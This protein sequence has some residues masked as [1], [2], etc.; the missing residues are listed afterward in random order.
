MTLLV[1]LCF[2]KIFSFFYLFS[3]FWMVLLGFLGP[4][5]MVDM[6][7]SFGAGTS[8]LQTLF[9]RG[10]FGVA[11]APACACSMVTLALIAGSEF[12]RW[13][14]CI[15]VTVSMF[16]ACTSS[17]TLHREWLVNYRVLY[18]CMWL[19]LCAIVFIASHTYG[20]ILYFRGRRKWTDGPGRRVKCAL[21]LS[22][23]FLSLKFCSLAGSYFIFKG[24]LHHHSA[25]SK[26]TEMPA[27]GVSVSIIIP[28][29][30]EIAR[31]ADITL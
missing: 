1:Q 4:H 25:Q 18:S 31:I 2:T 30:L 27:V 9:R 11:L 29:S 19:S 26:K 24:D 7:L 3:G 8:Q 16:T 28:L 13:Q 10:D 23:S 21:I 17:M 6:N 15:A 22:I 5:W 14:V 12:L 20:W